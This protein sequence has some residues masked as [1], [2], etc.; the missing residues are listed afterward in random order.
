MTDLPEKVAEYLLAKLP[1]L[2]A[3]REELTRSLVWHIHRGLLRAVLSD[4]RV[5]AAAA[6]R[7]LSEDADAKAERYRHEEDG[8]VLWVDW[9]AADAPAAFRRLLDEI[10]KRWTNPP[11]SVRGTRARRNKR[12]FNIPARRLAA[13]KIQHEEKHHGK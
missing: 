9:A 2:K 1:N 6:Y 7:R 8:A 5:V 13:G 12:L 3:T 10:P 11:G 4:G